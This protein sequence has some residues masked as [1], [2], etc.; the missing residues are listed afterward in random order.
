MFLIE[1]AAF[2]G[3]MHSDVIEQKISIHFD[4]LPNYLWPQMTSFAISHDGRGPEL[5]CLQHPVVEKNN[6]NL[7]NPE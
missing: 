4:Y 7:L 6:R 5:I 3:A 1:T 2:R